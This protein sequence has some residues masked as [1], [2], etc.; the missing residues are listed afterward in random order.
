MH[1]L[2][3]N[4]LAISGLDSPQPLSLGS[5]QPLVL[6]VVGRVC[7]KIKSA[8]MRGGQRWDV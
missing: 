7:G 8:G 6:V 5:H 2:C 4:A 3:S 1:G